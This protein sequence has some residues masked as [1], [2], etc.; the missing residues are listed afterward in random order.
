MP[1]EPDEPQ[2]TDDQPML[3]GEFSKSSKRG[4]AYNMVHNED[5]DAL[6]RGVSWWYNWYFKSDASMVQATSSE[7]TFIPMRWGR[8]PESDYDE[9]ERWLLAHPEIQIHLV[10]N[11]PNLVDKRI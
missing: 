1:N 8:N 6:E 5:F 7:M 11:E 10:L 9:L 3:T 2:Q 4:I